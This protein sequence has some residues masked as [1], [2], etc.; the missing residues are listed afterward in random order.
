[1]EISR[2]GFL[3]GSAAAAGSALAASV[4]LGDLE[5]LTPTASGAAQ[6]IGEEYIPTTC[7]IGKQDCGMLARKVNGRVVALTGHPSNPRNRGALCPKGVAQITAL[8]DANRVKAP[9]IRTN[10][11]G[12]PGTWRQ[13]SWDEALS[14][15]AEKMNEIRQRDPSLVAWQKGRSKAKPFYDKAFVKASGALKLHHGAFCSDAGYRALEYTIGMHAVLHP[16][17]R[18]TKYMLCW[19]WNVTNAGGN[20]FC[21]LT[22]PQKLVE[23]K[24][25]GMK[26]VAIDPRQ[27]S[28]AHFADEW[29][30]IRPGT[31]LALALALCNLLIEQGTIDTHYLKTYT[32]APFLVKED[33]FFLRAA[34]EAEGEPGQPLVWDPASRRAVPFGTEGVDPV[35]E[36]RF[37]VDGQSVKT[38]FQLF[39]EHVASM[40]AARAAQITGLSQDQ[41]RKVARELAENAMLG[42]SIEL[43]GMQLPYRPVGIMAYHMAQQELGFQALRAMVMIPMLLGAVGAVG[44]Q[45]SDFTWK[46]HKNWKGLD[47]ISITDTPNV[48]LKKSKFFPINSNNSSLVAKVMVDPEK[49]GV[50]KVPEMVIVHMANPLGSFADQEAN[51]AA[52]ERF[53]FVVVIDPWLSLTADLYADVVLPAATLEKYEGPISATDMYEDAKTMRIP[54]MEPMFDSRGDIQIYLDLCEAAGILYG[55]GGYLDQVNKA[56]KLEGDLALPLDRKPTVREIMDIWAKAQGLEEG[57]EF[58]EKNGVWV[59]GPVKAAKIYGYATDPPFGGAYPHRLYG[60]SLLRYQQEMKALG[61]DEIYWR[62]YTPLP[63]WRDLTVDQ[64]P[65]EYDLILISYHMIEFKQARTPLPMVREMARRQFMEINPQTARAKGIADGDEVWVESHNAI[66]G[67]TRRVKVIA[68]YRES[69]RPDTVAMPH[70]YGSLTKHPWSTDDGPTPNSLFFTGEGYVTNTADQTFLVKVKV[71]KA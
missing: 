62:D 13:A 69:I 4:L 15:V 50:E 8:Y 2:R 39:K 33:G 67:E 18:F 36:G 52:Y 31:D 17:F 34:P 6:T 26:M 57:V 38:A 71:T 49:Y 64:S 32:N 30:A 22:W 16:D 70:H 7:W 45:L 43:D 35:L 28:A 48:Y 10:E 66:T 41:I 63:T 27:R 19:G 9:L 65:A 42:S 46:V 60:E 59:K 23:A 53:K 68:R 3:K 20:K 14:L 58:F 51:K 37:T 54:V 40:P 56:L 29:L 12:V 61:V 47:E 5:T 24:A 1:M 44:G 25:R 11:K 21:W 55:E